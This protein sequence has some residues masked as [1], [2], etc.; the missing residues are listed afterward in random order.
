MSGSAADGSQGLQLLEQ[1]DAVAH[2][3]AVGRFEKGERLD[4]PQPERGHLE[5]HAREVR[6]QDLR[7]GELRPR[8]EVLLRI[9]PNADPVGDAAAA[10]L[11]LVGRRARDRLDR[12]PLHLQARA[13]ARDPREAGVD[14]EADARNRQRGLGDVRREH[15]APRLATL[16]PTE[17]LL[18]LGGR[19]PRVQ[20]QHLHARPQSPG[21][22]LCRVANLPLPREEREHVTVPLG[23]QLLDGVGERVEQLLVPLWRPVADLDRIRAAGDL[24]DRRAAEVLAETLRVDG[25]ARD[26]QLEIRATRQDAVQAAEQEVDVE[27]ALV[28]LVDD[29]RVVAAQQ[30]IAAD[31][32]KQQTVGDQ[33]NQGVLR[34]AIVKADRVADRAAKRD[35]ELIRD[36][37]CHGPRR[38]PS[39]LGVSD[40]PAHPTPELE[41]ELGQLG[42]LARAGLPGHDDHLVV[43]DRSEQ[44]VTTRGYRQLRRVGDRGDRRAPT[45]DPDARLGKLSLEPRPALLAAPTEP[46]RL[47]AK[48]LLVPQRQLAKRRLLDERHLH[49]A[50]PG[51][52]KW[53]A[54]GGHPIENRPRLAV[55]IDAPRELLQRSPI[56]DEATGCLI[57]VASR[58]RWGRKNSCAG[59]SE[60]VRLT[61]IMAAELRGHRAGHPL[62][63]G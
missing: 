56:K 19:E 18:L 24:D 58:T 42:R 32:G 12:Q 14:D 21:E 16:L 25:R 49:G 23:E 62:D 8:V 52:G 5:D 55:W 45:L 29:H 47:A 39:R 20:R 54:V 10:A 35:I 37:L 28:R 9:E 33:S 15:D 43:S 59:L 30:R 48:T 61:P 40:R 3:A 50:K 2:L 53:S 46:A 63:Q 6:A 27:R 51:G 1:R 17:D 38:D 31:L 36:P 44:V 60:G 13:V 4:V 7:V 41:A 11:A 22:Q 34:A 57:R 26:D